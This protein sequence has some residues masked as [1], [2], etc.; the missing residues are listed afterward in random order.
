MDLTLSFLFNSCFINMKKILLSLLILSIL[1]WCF[2]SSNNNIVGLTVQD[3]GEFSIQIPESWVLIGENDIPTPKSWSVAL[4]FS[5]SS[6]RQWY[7]NNIVI[8]TTPSLS[9]ASSSS[10]MKNSIQS[11]Q[12]NI[13]N[14]KI[15]EEKEV[16]FVDEQSG[17]IV[18]Y[19]GKYNDTTPVTTYIQTARV[20][21]NN[22][23]YLTISLA[24]SLES[25]D[26]YEYILQTFRCN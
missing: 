21:W 18:S 17:T 6:E 19:T 5:S 7:L 25:Y 4:A 13:E 14:F 10:L 15:I 3:W 11:L 16:I 20:C 2:W 23:Y 24:E 9:K 26:R 1:Q 22:N 12:K 8:L